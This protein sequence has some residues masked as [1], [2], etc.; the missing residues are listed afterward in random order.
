MG[1]V[2]LLF[3]L[4]T[5]FSRNYI[6]LFKKNIY[7]CWRKN[8]CCNRDFFKS[9]GGHNI[10]YVMINKSTEKIKRKR[11]ISAKECEIEL[12]SILSR[13]FEAYEDAVKQY[14]KEIVLTS[15]AARMRGFEAHLLNVKIVQSIQ[16]YFSSDWKTGKYGRFMLYVKGYIILFKKLNK[17]D[18]P[19]NIRT[20]M[21]DSIENQLQGRLFQDDEDPAAP[22]LFFGYK[23]NQ[24]G[25]LVDP[26][27]VYID[28]NKV[29][30]A[31]NKPATEHL[32]PTV[33]LKP[34]VPTTASVSLKDTNKVKTAENK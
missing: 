16:K 28:E 30:W 14:N 10:L 24:F 20:K 32:K 27:L 8:L 22:I 23:K 33:V 9:S 3:V 13:L 11:I 2:F 4:N 18:M 19:M 1:M 31:I 17:N 29:K 12:G 34:S 5:I 21:T 26:K 7:I 25:E 6:Q 15:P